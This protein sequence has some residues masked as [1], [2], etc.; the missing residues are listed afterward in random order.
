MV[1]VVYDIGGTNL[2]SA[3]YQNG[4]VIDIRRYKTPNY[5]IME[6]DEIKSCILDIIRC[7]FSDRLKSGYSIDGIAVCFPGPVS[8]DGNILGSSV[9]FG[10]RLK[11]NFN[12]KELLEKEFQ[13]FKIIVTNDITAAAYRYIERKNYCLITVSSGIGNKICI[14][15][16]VVIDKE[17]R[18]GEIGHFEYSGYK[19][20]IECSCGTGKD[21]VGMFSSGRGIEHFANKLFSTTDR[22]K[23]SFM[24]STLKRIIDNN[25]VILAEHVAIAADNGDDYAKNVIDFCTVPLAEVIALLS[26]ALYIPEFILIG[27]F[28]LKCNYYRKSLVKNTIRKGVYNFSDENIDCMIICGINDDNHGLIGLGKLFCALYS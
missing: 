24:K 26:I 8:E 28:A 27:G 1:A 3:Y 11:S 18:T 19:T 25:G 15:G 10:K 7:D 4:D 5:F 9:I 6:E 20:G 13:Q 16:K 14:G 17:G 21:H 22:F 12:L 23:D 2:R